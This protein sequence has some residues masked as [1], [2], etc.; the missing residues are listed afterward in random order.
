MG[1]PGPSIP[2]H[3]QAIYE[4]ELGRVRRLVVSFLGD[5]RSRTLSDDTGHQG[6]NIPWKEDEDPMWIGTQRVRY[7]RM[8]KFV[9]ERDQIVPVGEDLSRRPAASDD[10]SLR[11][12]EQIAG[13]PLETVLKDVQLNRGDFDADVEGY[14]RN[15][16][17]NHP[18]AYGVWPEQTWKDERT[19]EN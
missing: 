12:A 17:Q 7:T 6:W 15:D 10:V 18:R 16:R 19:G 9:A 11:F 8:V 14:R 5:E 2:S 13:I 1:C 3:E 4:V